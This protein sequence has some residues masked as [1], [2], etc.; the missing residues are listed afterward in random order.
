MSVLY[1]I[2]GFI[3]FLCIFWG[4]WGSHYFLSSYGFGGVAEVL[5]S[6]MSYVLFAV[7]LPILIL[8]MIALVIYVI[9]SMN[10]TKMIIANLLQISKSEMSGIQTVGKSLIEVRKLGFT[11]QFFVNMPMILND[12]SQFIA[13]IIAKAGIASDVVI[14]DALSKTGDNRLYAVCRIILD[15]R[16]STPHFDES[17]RRL[18]KRDESLAGVISIFSDKYDK[19]LRIVSKYDLD[20][21][22]SSILEEGELG[23]VRNVL[24]NALN[25][26]DETTGRHANVFDSIED[27]SFMQ[28]NLEISPIE[29]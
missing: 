17:L 23:K 16:E 2:I 18:L 1:Y 12:M 13:D 11:N 28:E 27:E 20:G 5:P 29:K 10:Q 22:V 6:D 4:F 25:M 9:A 21:F 26:K 3:C 8:L 19:L 7:G 15:K 14:Y 24:L